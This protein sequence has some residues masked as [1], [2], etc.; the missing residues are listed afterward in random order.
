MARF[1]PFFCAYK[2]ITIIIR[3][4]ITNPKRAQL[5]RSARMPALCLRRSTPRP[6]SISK[7]LLNPHCH[8]STPSMRNNHYHTY[9]NKYY[10]LQASKPGSGTPMVSH[11][12][13]RLAADRPQR[14]HIQRHSH[15]A[16]TTGTASSSLAFAHCPFFIRQMIVRGLGQVDRNAMNANISPVTR[17]PALTAW[18]RDRVYFV[19][20]I[21]DVNKWG[22]V[23]DWE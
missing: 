4:S 11:N 1:I 22:V 13:S 3:R 6:P 21:L 23:I 8:K 12:S 2:R 5:Q 19:R 20:K 16:G 18:A 15:S 14:Y 17:A 10:A 7:P 9:R